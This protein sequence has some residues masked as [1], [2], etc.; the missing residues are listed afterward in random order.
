MLVLAGTDW[1]PATADV[2]PGTDAWLTTEDAA[3]TDC[4]IEPLAGTDW[5]TAALPGIDWLTALRMD[6]EPTDV[7]DWE[8]G[9]ADCALSG[10]VETD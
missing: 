3:G 10:T 2:L 9:T 1:L 7:T 6:C 5:V 4:V 8:P